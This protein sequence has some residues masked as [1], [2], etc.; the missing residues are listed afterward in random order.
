MTG[1]RV[2]TLDAVVKH[3][4]HVENLI[5]RPQILAGVVVALQAP[6]HLQARV[7]KHQRHLID[8]AVTGDATDPFADMNIVP[9]IDEIRQVMNARPFERDPGAPTL[10][11]GIEQRGVGPDA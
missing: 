9:E 3:E 10:P 11:H 6:S 8:L 1:V 7:L 2:F 4:I 5:A